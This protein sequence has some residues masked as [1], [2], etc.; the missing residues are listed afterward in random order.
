MK[1]RELVRY[2]ERQGCYL[3]REGGNHSIYVNPVNGKISA[4]GRHTEIADRMAK[5]ICK[6]LD[7]PIP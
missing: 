5:I 4:V 2:L 6:Q 1:R 3:Q 7:L